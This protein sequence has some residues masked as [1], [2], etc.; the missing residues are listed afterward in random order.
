MSMDFDEPEDISE[1]LNLLGAPKAEFA[2]RGRAFARNLFLGP[3]LALGG[4]TLDIVLFC[5][6]HVSFELVMVGVGMLLTGVMLV[7]R[8]YRNR[9]LRILVFTEGLVRVRGNDG[10]ALFWDEIETVWRKKID[11]HWEKIWKGGLNYSVQRG[12]GKTIEFDDSIPELDELGRILNKETF[13][14]LW[15]RY[16]AAYEKGTTIPFGQLRINKR[17]LNT[18]SGKVTW[19]EVQEAKFEDNQYTISKK[20][21]WTSWFQG[22]VAQTP[23]YHV[24]KA[25][26]ERAMATRSISQAAGSPQDESETIA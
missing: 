11:G 23:N 3:L 24:C 19:L 12:D 10:Q 8:A 20:G 18:A 6:G 17:G 1:K 26:I 4:L 22:K 2:V 14:Y 9:G 13:V 21:K 16:L 7:V 25:L 15:P 5:F